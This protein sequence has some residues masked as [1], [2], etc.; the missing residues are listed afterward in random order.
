M[1]SDK[2]CH[3]C[4]STGTTSSVFQT[5]DELD[6]ER[7]IWTAAQYGELDRVVKILKSGTAIDARDNFGYTALHYAARN[8]HVDVCKL[9]LQMGADIN[10]IT[11]SGC[12]TALHRAASAGLL[13]FIKNT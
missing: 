5:L 11:K 7:G 13:Y 2:C 3:T 10:A 6:F 1:D 9:L 8:G 12:V 4:H